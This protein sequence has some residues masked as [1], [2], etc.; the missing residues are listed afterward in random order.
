MRLTGNRGA[1][2]WNRT[3]FGNLT[4]QWLC[5]VPQ[6]DS[7]TRLFE[8]RQKFHPETVPR[9]T[10]RILGVTAA[11]WMVSNDCGAARPQDRKETRSALILHGRQLSMT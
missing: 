1:Q 5:L 8:Q 6:I 7:F 11:Y 3:E 9:Q 4:N 10:G 2:A